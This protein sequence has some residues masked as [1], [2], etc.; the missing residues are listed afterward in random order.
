MNIIDE[1]MK[2]CPHEKVSEEYVTERKR[3]EDMLPHLIN[4][5]KTDL[6]AI[7]EYVL[8][9]APDHKE[10]AYLEKRRASIVSKLDEAKGY[11]DELETTAG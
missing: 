2:D 10:R 1:L 4:G 8:T 7:D 11:D 3:Y 6:Q 9:L 5:L